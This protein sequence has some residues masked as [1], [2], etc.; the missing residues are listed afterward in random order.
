MKYVLAERFFKL[1]FFAQLIYTFSYG[2]ATIK[3]L[4]KFA[5]PFI[6]V[7]HRD[8]LKGSG[9]FIKISNKPYFVTAHHMIYD[10]SGKILLGNAIYI[11]WMAKLNTIFKRH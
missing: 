11:F 3:D 1:L 8:T 4:G 9:F 7:K 2:Q 6:I 5:Y 10:Q